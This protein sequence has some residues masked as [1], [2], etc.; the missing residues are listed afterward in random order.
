MITGRN[1]NGGTLRLLQNLCRRSN[2]IDTRNHRNA[3]IAA[4]ASGHAKYSE[5]ASCAG[6]AD[7]SY[8][9]KS[10]VGADILERR[11]SSGKPYYVLN[12]R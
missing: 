9:L 5:I 11:V 10:L 6:M 3:I 12:H 4:V 7:I 2:W 8:Y 1:R